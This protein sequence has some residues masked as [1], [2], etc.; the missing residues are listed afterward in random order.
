MEESL[1]KDELIEKLE[2][3]RAEYEEDEKIQAAAKTKFD[4]KIKKVVEANKL[5]ELE[6]LLRERDAELAKEYEKIKIGENKSAVKPE[7]QNNASGLKKC[8]NPAVNVGEKC[9]DRQLG[10][11]RTKTGG[12]H[13]TLRNHLRSRRHTYRRI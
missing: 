2:K 6:A 13:Q 4:E 5:K 9:F 12:Y 10:V 7:E 1:R 8:G 11:I 3:T